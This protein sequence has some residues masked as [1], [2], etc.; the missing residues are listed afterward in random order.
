[1]S[2]IVQ[3]MIRF[4]IY[5]KVRWHRLGGRSPQKIIYHIVGLFHV[6]DKWHA[7]EKTM[8]DLH[9]VSVHELNNGVV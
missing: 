5:M 6:L 4:Q 9:K 7:Y 3:V 1:M 8:E 2:I